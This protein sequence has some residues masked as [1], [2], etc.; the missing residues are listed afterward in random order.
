MKFISK[1][2]T[3]ITSFIS[4]SIYTEK[5]ASMNGLMQKIDARA[6]LVIVLAFIFLAVYTSSIW[7]LAFLFTIAI[8]LSIASRISIRHYM[9]RVLLFIPLFTSIVAIPSIF[10]FIT[11]GESIISFLG[12]SITYEGARAA[13]FLIARVTAAVSFSILLITTTRW[14]ELMNAMLFFKIPKIFVMIAE[15]S[16]RYIFLLLHSFQ[17]MML[18]AKSRA[19]SRIGATKAWKIYAP[20]MGAMFIKTHEMNEKVYLSMLSRGYGA[21]IKGNTKKMRIDIGSTAAIAVAFLTVIAVCM[22]L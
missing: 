6:K 9:S 20:I 18:S 17:N 22:I 7:V 16:Y 2:L 12:I 10:S 13:S 15:M 3:E 5:Y 19:V 14:N 11:P 4:A 8:I 1:T 21:E